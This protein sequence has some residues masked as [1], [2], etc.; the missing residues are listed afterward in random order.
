MK[1]SQATCYPECYDIT[2]KSWPGS[3]SV[4]REDGFEYLMNP[5]A[6]ETG[7]I[8]YW[9]PSAEDLEADDWTAFYIGEE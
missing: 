9:A 8:G 4:F 1:Y 6:V 3:W 7:D 2:R 5:E